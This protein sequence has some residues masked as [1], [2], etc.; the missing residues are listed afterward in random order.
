MP[1]SGGSSRFA[2]LTTRL[3]EYSLWKVYA[4]GD[5]PAI[6]AAPVLPGRPFYV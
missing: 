5:N 3:T 4:G 2:K 1:M 6:K